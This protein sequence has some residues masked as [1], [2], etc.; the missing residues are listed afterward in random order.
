MDNPAAP[1]SGTSGGKQGK[2]GSGKR[3]NNRPKPSQPANSA[4][5][6]RSNG[7]RGQRNGQGKNNDNSSSVDTA[8]PTALSHPEGMN[9]MN[10]LMNMGIP[11]SVGPGSGSSVV[12]SGD[13]AISPAQIMGITLSNSAAQ[14]QRS[15]PPGGFLNDPT[16]HVAQHFNPPPPNSFN[17]PWAPANPVPNHHLNRDIPSQLHQKQFIDPRLMPPMVPHLRTPSPVMSNTL[18]HNPQMFSQVQ[19]L[20]STPPGL[21][22]TFNSVPVQ[23]QQVPQQQQHRGG[24]DL[25]RQNMAQQWMSARQQMPL[26]LQSGPAYLGFNQ[27]EVV[28]S[29]ETGL[30]NHVQTRL[31]I[32]SDIVS[33]ETRQIISPRAENGTVRAAPLNETKRNLQPPNKTYPPMDFIRGPFTNQLRNIIASNLAPLPNE[34]QT[35][36]NVLSFLSNV[37][38]GVFE[39]AIVKPFGST[40]SNLHLRGAADI[41]LCVLLDEPSDEHDPISIAWKKREVEVSKEFDASEA[42][43]EEEWMQR[44]LKRVAELKALKISKGADEE[45]IKDENDSLDVDEGNGTDKKPD[46]LEVRAFKK[47]PMK[48]FTFGHFVLDQ[49]KVALENESRISDLSL[50]LNTRIPIVKFEDLHSKL[51]ID[52]GYFNILGIHNTRLIATYNEIDP[53]F[54]E[55]VLFVKHWAKR[56]TIN[57]TYQGTLSSY[58]YVLMVI[59]YMQYACDPPILPCLQ[60]INAREETARLIRVDDHAYNVYFFDDLPQ[61]H[62]YFDVGR[63]QQTLGE[64]LY[65]FFYYWAH[66]FDFKKDVACIRNGGVLTK[67]EKGWIPL[68]EQMKKAQEQPVHTPSDDSAPSAVIEI[69][70]TK[71]AA[72][73]ETSNN[74]EERKGLQRY[75]VCIEDPFEIDHNLGRPVG[76][77]S[78]YFIRGEFLQACN[79]LAQPKTFPRWYMTSLSEGGNPYRR[80]PH[81][82]ELLLTESE[83]KTREEHKQRNKAN[84]DASDRRKKD[85][86]QV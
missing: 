36:E 11:V 24:S 48:P 55:M 19:S 45:D 50:I 69:E 78:L 17:N 13:T 21:R 1:T 81:V 43:R 33:S 2:R 23:N 53:R 49:V 70:D 7:G 56:K 6:Q 83:F 52:I 75:W 4:G 37:V 58:A 42:D 40:A 57:D 84:M 28:K 29:H 5:N 34:Y 32:S 22:Q 54:R 82:A 68:I 39:K 80:A 15:S 67:E 38:R 18:P 86:Q 9:V 41:D 63:N 27:P 51:G 16:L 85:R 44:E 61:L 47:K 10:M 79:I 77:D 74:S 8:E 66:V 71:S 35:F 30:E 65:G 73:A 76:R 62:K 3:P 64:L 72:E 46:P 14:G 25:S 26:H 59:H 20:F 60:S 12:E 31:N